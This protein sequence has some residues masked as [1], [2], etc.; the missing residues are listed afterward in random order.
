MLIVNNPNEL[1]L[2]LEPIR[3]LSKKIG[4]VPTMGALHAG[5]LSLVKAALAHCEIVVVSI[6]VN[7]TQFNNPDDLLKYPRTL[8]SDLAQLFNT[9]CYM[10]YTPDTHAIYPNTN[11]LKPNVDIRSIENVMEGSHRP[12]HFDGVIQV[13]DILLKHVQPDMLFLGQKDYQQCAVLQQLVN[14]VHPSIQLI[15]VPTMRDPDGLAMSSRNVRLDAESRAKAPFIFATL[16]EISTGWSS[17]KNQVFW[18]EFGVNKIQDLG[19]CDY[20]TLADASTLQ[21]V[22]ASTKRVVACV[23]VHVGGVRLIDNIVFDY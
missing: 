2:S 13:V 15:T 7:P 1:N 10:V 8:T 12:G 18:E 17:H 14:Q 23:A 9:N 16:Q 11:T 4:F 6:F 5:H 22:N 3:L 20:V 19:K 21:A